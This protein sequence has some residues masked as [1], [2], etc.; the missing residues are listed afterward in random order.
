MVTRT[1]KA[2]GMSSLALL[3]LMVSHALAGS[4][5]SSSSSAIDILFRDDLLLFRYTLFLFEPNAH[6]FYLFILSSRHSKN[7]YK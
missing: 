4:A 1:I 5:G 3:G 6:T 7:E 2:V